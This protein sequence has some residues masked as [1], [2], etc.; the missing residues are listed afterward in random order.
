VR[1]VTFTE[2]LYSIWPGEKHE[3]DDTGYEPYFNTNTFQ[4]SYSTLTQPTVLYDYDMDT[5]R[6]RKRKEQVVSGYVREEYHQKRIFAT[7]SDGQLVPISLVYKISLKNPNGNPLLLN[8]Y[9]AYG[10]HQL[11][12]F[13][14]EKLSLLD[15]GIIYALVHPRGDAIWGTDWYEQGKFL[16]KKNTFTDFIAAAEFLIAEGY[17]SADRLAIV[18][19]S[20]GGLLMGAVA[21]MAP[22]LFKVCLR[23]LDYLSAVSQ[24]P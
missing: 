11:P 18:G 3:T 19:R 24:Y 8:G 17:T 7:A 16:Q 12:Y 6:K 14:P 15:R 4:F 21:N 22:H 5:H 1:Y 23:L 10:G 13:E 2:P 20:A 9:G